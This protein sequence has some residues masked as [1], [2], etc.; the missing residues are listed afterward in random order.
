MEIGKT[1]LVGAERPTPIPE[2]AKTTEKSGED[3]LA[4]GVRKTDEVFF[5]TGKFEAD[6]AHFSLK[7]PDIATRVTDVTISS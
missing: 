4:H 1:K 3:P 6:R 7:A 5:K 2:K